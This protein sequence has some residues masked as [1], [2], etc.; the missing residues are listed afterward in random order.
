MKS[1]GRHAISSGQSPRA[2]NQ[3]SRSQQRLTRAVLETLEQRQ[4]LT[5][6]VS[7]YGSTSKNEGSSYTLDLGYSGTAPT[8]WSIDW[9]DGTTSS[10]DVQNVSGNPSSIAHTYVDGLNSYIISAT[11]A[12]NEGTFTAN[13]WA[14]DPDFGTNGLV[15]GSI[16]GSSRL[17][18]VQPDGKFILGA[19]LFSHN[20]DFAMQRYD[21]DGHLDTSFG[22]N[23]VVATDFSSS[24]SD[25]LSALFLQPDGKILAAG[26]SNGNF[27]LARYDSSGNLDTTFNGTGKAVAPIAGSISS[28]AL[29]P[30]GE[31][32]AAGT[33][34]YGYIYLARFNADGTL[35]TNF[36]GTGTIA[37]NTYS[38]TDGGPG[39]TIQS[40]G[41]ILLAGTGGPAGI[42][43]AVTRYNTNGTLDSSFGSGGQ[44][45]THVE[46]VLG[47][48]AIMLQPDGKILV[49]AN[50]DM[51]SFFTLLRY[52]SSG[53]LDSGFGNNGVVIQ[54]SNSYLGSFTIDSDGKILVPTASAVYRYNADGSSDLSFNGG[55]FAISGFSSNSTAGIQ[56][57]GK[58]IVVVSNQHFAVERIEPVDTF[59]VQINNVPPTATF[60]AAT[61]I[62]AGQS[63]HITFTNPTDPS[64]VD[65]TAGFH[66]S[67]ATSQ[68]ALAT[69]YAAAGASSSTDIAFDTAG[70]FT[71]YGR[72]FD[73]DGGYTDYT[74]AQVV[75]SKAAAPSQLVADQVEAT[76]LILTW[77]DN[78]DDE[79]GFNVY[80]S[81]NG[82]A[83]GAATHISGAH[84]GVDP[85]QYTVTGLTGGSTYAF[86]VSATRGNS[87]SDLSLPAIVVTPSTNASRA[88]IHGP[89]SAQ[90]GDVVNLWADGG[91]LDGGT[92]ALSYIWNIKK[93]GKAFDSGIGTTYNFTPDAPATYTADLT[94]LGSGG[95]AVAQTLSINVG[96]SV[97]I[98]GS[99]TPP[100]GHAALF[101][102]NV[103]AHTG[104]VSYAW[105]VWRVDPPPSEDEL[106]LA[107]S[108]APTL[109]F[110][111]TF[112]GNGSPDNEFR[113]ELQVTMG[114]ATAS[115]QKIIT[116]SVDPAFLQ[117][118]QYN[119]VPISGAS[120]WDANSNQGT[121]AGGVALARQSNGDLVQAGVLP[122]PFNQIMVVRYTP[123]L[124]LDTTFNGTGKVIL[125]TTFGPIS[126]LWQ[127]ANV[128][129]APDNKILVLEGEN[130]GDPITG[131]N[132]GSFVV[133]R[134][135]PDGQL[136]T[137]F[138]TGGLAAIEIPQG[139]L[140]TSMLVLSDGSI[141]IGGERLEHPT[142]GY[143][144]ERWAVVKLTPEGA[145]D[146]TFGNSGIYTYG[147]A[148]DASQVGNYDQNSE[149]V[150]QIAVDANG[151]L[152]LAGS[153]NFPG[154]D[155]PARGI[156]IARL[157]LHGAL[158]TTFGDS[159]THFVY[160]KNILDT[161]ISGMVIQPDGRFIIA[162]GRTVQLA[163]YNS[164]G[165][166]DTSFGQAHSGVVDT[167]ISVDIGNVE[168]STALGG[169]ALDTRGNVI[170]S[171]GTASWHSP[172]GNW[173]LVR[174]TA[175][176][177]LDTSFGTQSDGKVLMS[178]PDILRTDEGQIISTP[179]GIIGVGWS[180]G[181][182]SGGVPDFVIVRYRAPT[183]TAKNLT[184]AAL[185][186]GTVALKWD[187]IGDTEDGFTISRSLDTNPAHFT[188]IGDVPT[189]QTSYIDATVA[190]GTKYYYKVTPFIG[191]DLQ[192]ESNVASVTTA[193][194]NTGYVLQDIVPVDMFGET[195]QSQI[196]LDQNAVYMLQ[197]SGNLSQTLDGVH[198]G[199]A[200]YGYF[201]YLGESKWWDG[202]GYDFGIGIDDVD[203]VKQNFW[204]P[205]AT[206]INHTYNAMFTGN[207]QKLS[208]VY[209]DSNYPDNTVSNPGDIPLTVKIYRALPSAPAL[210]T[211]DAD[212]ANKQINLSWQNL[213]TDGQHILVERSEDDGE[214]KQIASLAPTATTYSDNGV[215]TDSGKLDLNHKYTYRIRVQN[216]F[217]N[218]GYTKEA[219]A[220]LV[221]LLPTIKQIPAQIAQVGS[222]FSIKFNA[223]D[224]EDGTNGLVFSTNDSNLV[225]RNPIASNSLLS[226]D[227]IFNWTPGT[228]DLGKSII[229][230]VR[231]A[232][233]DSTV[234]SPS[235]VEE[236][237]TI[238]VGPNP[239][240]VPHVTVTS[241]VEA[242]DSTKVDLSAVIDSGPTSNLAYS[243]SAVTIPHGVAAPT[244]ENNGAT[245][246][247]TLHGAGTYIF[248]ATVNDGTEW[249]GIGDSFIFVESQATQIVLNPTS[250]NIAPGDT[251]LLTPTTLDQFGRSF[252]TG[253]RWT[254]TNSDAGGSLT[255]LDGVSLGANGNN[256]LST[257]S[258]LYHAPAN[259]SGTDEIT[260]DTE[261]PA[262]GG[263]QLPIHVVVSTSSNH[264]PTAT[265]IVATAL[266]D[267]QLQL[268]V[269]GHDPDAG[270]NDSNLIYHWSAAAPSNPNLTLLPFPQFSAND[271][272][273]ASSTIATLPAGF[274]FENYIFTVTITDPGNAILKKTLEITS[275]H[276]FTSI[277]FNKMPK[278]I[279]VGN[280]VT[281]QVS[282]LDQ[283]GIPF[284]DEPT[285]NWSIVDDATNETIFTSTGTSGDSSTLTHTFDS[286]GTAATKSYHVNVSATIDGVTKT[287]S[288]P[289]T[290]LAS[291]SPVLRIITPA[292]TDSDSA[293]VVS[294]DS[295][296]SIVANNDDEDL[297][298]AV[299]W[300]LWLVAS[301]G[302][303]T[304]MNK[305]T[306]SEG[307]APFSG[308]NVATIH[309]TNLPNGLYTL[310]LYGNLDGSGTPADNETIQIKSN[311]K[312]GSLNFPV[313]DL[314]VNVPGGGQ[315]AFTRSY[316][317]MRANQ[318]SDLG[319]G[320]RSLLT[321]DALVTTAL[322]SIDGTS[323]ATFREGDLAY[324]T[325]PD[326]S[327]RAFE[328][329]PK[330]NSVGT[331]YYPRFVSVDGSGATLDVAGDASAATPSLLSRNANGEFFTTAGGYYNPATYGGQYTLQTV[332][333]S[334]Y[335]VDASTNKLLSSK[336]PNGNVTTYGSTI[337]SGG[338][339]LKTDK[340]SLGRITEVS[341]VDASGNPISGVGSVSYAYDSSGNLITVTG[342]DGNVT[343]YAY[344]AS[345]NLTQVTDARGV[346]VLSAQYNP[347][348][349]ILD[350]LTDAAGHSVP[351]SEPSFAGDGSTASQSSSD[352][353]GQETENIYDDHGNVARQIQTQRDSAGNITGY[354][355]TV[356]NYVYAAD[357]LWDA[358]S[359]GI[360]PQ[361]RLKSITDYQPFFVDVSNASTRYTAGGSQIARTVLY[362]LNPASPDLGQVASQTVYDAANVA[363]VTTFSSYVDGKSQII[364]SV[365][366]GIT[367]YTYN[368][369][370]SKGNLQWTLNNLGE[371][372]RYIYSGPSG[373][374]DSDI[375]GSFT[376]PGD[377]SATTLSG[378]PAGLQI[379]SY[380]IHITITTPG[381]LP[382][383]SSSAGTLLRS[384]RYN[385]NGTVQSTTDATT[386]LMT[387]YTYTATGQVQDVTR[388]WTD[389]QG[390]H[391][392]TD[393]HTTYDSSGR[394]S[395]VTNANGKTTTTTYNSV[396]KV[397][398]KT[399]QYSGVTSYTYDS[400]GKLIRTQY[401]DGTETRTVYDDQGRA[402]W[403]ADR[404]TT[405]A[406]NSG[407]LATHTIYDNLGRVI[408][409]ER[410][411]N[412][413]L[414][415]TTDSTASGLFKAVEPAASSLT[416]K[417]LSST[418]TSYD[419]QGRV[420]ETDSAS[421]LRTGTIYYLNGQVQY[422]GVLKSTVTGQWWTGVPLL[423]SSVVP[424][425]YFD[426]FTSYQYN[427][428]DSLPTGAVSYDAVID[429]NGNTTKTYKDS[430]GRVIQ[431]TY[432]D[433][434]FTQTIYSVSDQAISDFDVTP[435]IPAGGSEQIKIAQRKSS[436]PVVAT[437]YVY[438]AAE[439]LTD[440]YLPAVT[441]ADPNSATHNLFVRPHWH[442]T[443]D[444][445]GNELTQV[446][447]KDNTTSFTYDELGN[448]I[449]RT[450]PDNESESWTY[451]SFGRMLTHVDFKGQSSKYIYDNSNSHGGQLIEED[452]FTGAIDSTPDEKCIYIYD[453]LGRQAEVDEYAGTTLTRQTITSY[454]PISGNISQIVSP[455]G[456]INYA[457][458][459][460]T[461]E[462]IEIWTGTNHSAAAND[463][464]YGYDVQGRLASVTQ[465]RLNGSASAAVANTTR[466]DAVGNSISTTMPTTLYTYDAV[467]DLK[468]T[469]EPNGIVT[470][471]TY[472]NLNRL[473]DELVTNTITSKSVF[474]EHYDLL[475]N[476]LR[477]DVVDTHYNADGSIFSKIQTN[478]SYDAD[479]RLI[480][481]QEV[482]ISGNGT[483]VP[484]AYDDK[485]FFDLSNNR[486]KEDIN[487]G[488]AATA[489][490]TI[491]YTYDNDDQLQTETGTLHGGATDYT[492]AYSYDD[493]GSLTQQVGTGS[494]AG[495]DVYTYDL[496][497]RMISATIANT[498]TNYGYD[499]DGVRVSEIT[500][501]LSTYYLND[502]NNPT[503]YSKAIQESATVGGSPN[504]S[505][506]L[507]QKVE[508]QSDATNGTL[509]FV[510]DGHGSTRAV[511]NSSGVVVQ[512]YDYDAFGTALDFSAASAKT[513]W[514]FGGDGTY[515]PSSGFTYQLARWRNGF[516]FT[517]ADSSS[518]DTSDPQS[519]HKY[520]YVNANPINS[521]D[522]TGHDS[523]SDDAFGLAE[524]YQGENLL[525]LQTVIGSFNESAV[526][527]EAS[528]GASV[529]VLGSAVGGVIS[530]WNN[531]LTS[532]N[533][534]SILQGAL[535]GAW[536]GIVND[537]D[538]LTFHRF[539][540]LDN[541]RNE[542]WDNQGLTNSWIGKT[543]NGF[544]WAGTALLYSAAAA[545]TWEAAGGGTM[546]ISVNI[547][548]REPFL[549]HVQY[550]AG[551]VF[552]D[553]TGMGLGNMYVASAKQVGTVIS[554]IPVLYPESVLIGSG[555][556]ASCVTAAVSAL[557]RGWGL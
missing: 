242:N 354:L 89:Q 25:L 487:G 330:V 524:Q 17:V 161:T 9:G 34:N 502:P 555:T 186:D 319:D 218:S 452:R 229:V 79:D 391:A 212:R 412:V 151:N 542:L 531:W 491:N 428:T 547:S 549:I 322:P 38:L 214:F 314:A 449:S 26:S 343:H 346:T 2:L 48:R 88:F 166:I 104:S 481:E 344:D 109:R 375:L 383:V 495:T 352:S 317:S 551:G 515:D 168:D 11:A 114:G 469:S 420:A 510:T 392:V 222:L 63:A 472:D 142:Q 341:V 433:T 546:D 66:Y 397:A 226:N 408:G 323:S 204:G 173:V 126:Q 188:E 450:L 262:S 520:V 247:A 465:V 183:N 243:W 538:A 348:T 106:P 70:T 400:R 361:N 131:I 307:F 395:T 182:T 223:N 522:P 402:I 528:L 358:D 372:T 141:V 67:F 29:G 18:L 185:P 215:G 355:V 331:G 413:V 517:Q 99:S 164:N 27:A 461:G 144:S 230:K 136:D 273:S 539:S 557:L 425:N 108:S 530:G 101:T 248:R 103:P 95:A 199:D 143:F 385:S 53:V 301:D 302:S 471:D 195:T 340:D 163:R 509:Y 285:F 445:N 377:S 537:V 32:A 50:A 318:P 329:L 432:Q 468:T 504:R 448:R 289:L 118:Y 473:T 119:T 334:I 476:G 427:K 439:R 85:V 134:L 312:L 376:Y 179:D 498:T 24:S 156:A 148:A 172:T 253:Y 415:L 404:N 200:E 384:I 157:T 309:P 132:P 440:V 294:G 43:I 228:N 274:S 267:T 490:E 411:K 511:A 176:G 417:K 51:D 127:V 525:G 171:A 496:H 556:A 234:A 405:D 388:H 75:I 410:Y 441:D 84:S 98:L 313:T 371:G 16:F 62:T 205:L 90:T 13:H 382:S 519:L 5:T 250:P 398:I 260:I 443:Y 399:D 197:A 548:T 175:D 365:H 133:A 231:V 374:T 470:T 252:V 254:L 451:D 54:Q 251:L 30:D 238:T 378:L 115:A 373:S 256:N 113:V 72:I 19:A 278:S 338:M 93:D 535:Q 65:T 544:A 39:V 533:P 325:L 526:N 304:M 201:Y 333:G 211:A 401:P 77:T 429:A 122:A 181:P 94:A 364:Q 424:G 368:K 149:N 37:T 518:G 36:N 297:G 310:N 328:F 224:P 41:K 189:D 87:E 492:I 227:G 480:E 347:G 446:D 506:V 239:S 245:A 167:G 125:P 112:N 442:Y 477:S 111:P 500:G 339:H 198:R 146:T 431:T 96:L 266:N 357:D 462:L 466:Y 192:I 430:L 69:T 35:D 516:E 335:T 82:S 137:T 270:S 105:K 31:I 550:G 202:A 3:Q 282:A 300:S 159:D 543:A 258:V 494:K 219:Y 527:M 158:D 367:T 460:A 165:T 40:D 493:N 499:N 206:D 259:A 180:A 241:S 49:G 64:S 74:A 117:D 311:F 107:T 513:T 514:L 305:G 55:R 68:A 463:V 540:T 485:F 381:T 187:D 447:P 52:S 349:G 552:E 456:T 130:D 296:V 536:A 1:M 86:R 418:S 453:L 261:S 362:N 92:G 196:T 255:D 288:A 380:R 15:V 271:T 217:G 246:I 139:H 275:S 78:A 244:F 534:T 459:N 8:S 249:P 91:N 299:N 529:D 23:G 292:A 316:S 45:S 438:D 210:L 489:G 73:K 324:I 484:T 353:S 336:D 60:A 150:Q 191:N 379:A 486:T 366:N 532:S 545:F 467:G 221:N 209:H 287:S 444:A 326:G 33:Y 147:G 321:D 28:I 47:V 512:T 59:A 194:T 138:G 220:V 81:T 454:D 356:H 177:I 160:I 56:S 129:I 298:N 7:I 178:P 406:L 437:I 236:S 235:F 503:G 140:A 422:S 193:P 436:D 308:S 350:Q 370:D 279:L 293:V 553:A 475:N 521:T 10:P 342:Q 337:S 46:G 416:G 457:Y 505:Y 291:A 233:Q 123:D 257:S 58:I 44:V 474:L 21:S 83:F 359:T 501:S 232:D 276:D 369:Y 283:L 482:I 42:D 124:Q 208:V 507:G 213:A 170:L 541:Y 281:F 102:A 71:V 225:P 286:I 153:M 488:S 272:N 61:T 306:K 128:A 295:Q 100:G 345:H 264:A 403:S 152:L 332:D 110:T 423:P 523:L 435:I 116:S 280:P 277:Q 407:A 20:S 360:S 284:T 120:T 290:V 315:L 6:T 421:G 76:Q 174:Y 22:V 269:A 464:L 508:A 135:N 80:Q 216:N 351:F 184:A 155:G 207:G 386:D 414:T 203:G 327:Q 393:S 14:V 57:D 145:L 320:W 121:V 190:P 394:V 419:H 409:T 265:P 554:G 479:D 169:L 154:A 483:N 363:S 396:G 263:P 455:E 434:S 390:S 4:Y 97:Q 303:R 497:N 387:S 478:W 162:Y 237:F 240:T 12:N 268:S 426:S 389:A 458:D